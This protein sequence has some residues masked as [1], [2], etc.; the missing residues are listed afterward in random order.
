MTISISRRSVLGAAASVSLPLWRGA[1]AAEPLNAGRFA[2]FVAAQRVDI[3]VGH[4]LNVLDGYPARS[5][6]REVSDYAFAQLT[7][8]TLLGVVKVSEP[9]LRQVMSLYPGHDLNFDHLLGMGRAPGVRGITYPITVKGTRRSIVM[10]NERIATNG[11]QPGPGRK[12]FALVFAHE[13]THARNDQIDHAVV[14]NPLIPALKVSPVGTEANFRLA[15]KGYLTELAARHVS[16]QVNQDIEV[17][18]DGRRA[19]VPSR[20]GLWNFCHDMAHHAYT[21]DRTYINELLFASPN[22]LFPKQLARWVEYFAVHYD[23]SSDVVR[24]AAV[25]TLFTDAVLWAAPQGYAPIK[26]QAADGGTE[27]WSH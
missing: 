5:W 19:R 11:T 3:E 25:K 17:K 9:R 2:P 20:S 15:M 8:E 26:N 12:L 7:S 27:D 24:N 1:A 16:W 18:W 13:F 22:D 23:F 21:K 6:A 14:Q 4:V 10:V